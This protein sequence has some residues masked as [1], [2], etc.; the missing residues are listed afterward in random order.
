MIEPELRK[1]ERDDAGQISDWL[2]RPEIARY[3]SENLRHG[4]MTPMLVSAGLRRRDQLWM[5]FAPASGAEPCGLISLDGIEPE[6]GHANVWFLLGDAARAGQGLTSRALHLFCRINPAGLRVL[7]AWAVAANRASLRCM[8]K[9][10]FEPV[11]RIRE[12]AL[13][14]GVRH[15]RIVMQRLLGQ[16]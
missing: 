3:L 8:E 15:D 2:N 4:G 14:E 9:A 1:A 10:G 6:D 7:S 16:S 13:V 11:G 5:L 12:G